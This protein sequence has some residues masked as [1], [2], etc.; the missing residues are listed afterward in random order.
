MD[1]SKRMKNA[2]VLLCLCGLQAGQLVAQEATAWHPAGDKIMSPWAEELTTASPLPEYPR[3]QLV[4][5]G[6]QNLN[7]LWDYAIVPGKLTEVPTAYSG[8]ILVPFAVESALSGV[9]K[10]V[11]KD[12]SLWYRR[13]VAI[14][15]KMRNQRVLLHFGAVDWQCEVYVNGQQAGSHEGGFDPFTIDITPYL[16]KGANQEI[17]VGVWDPTDE[18]PQP[19]GKQVVRPHG[20]WY[21]PVTG[22]WQTVW[23]EGVPETYI[24][25]TKH[26]PDIDRSSLAVEATIEGLRQGDEVRISAWNGSEKVAEAA[27][28]GKSAITLQLNNPQLWSPTNP[29]LYDLKVAVIRKGKAVDEV[30]SYFAMRKISMEKDK[31]GIQ[32]MLLN[33]E[34]VFQYGPLDQG[35]WPDGLYTAPTDEALRFD[36]EKTKDMGFNMIRKHI[37]VEPARWYYYCDSIGVLVWQDMPSGD[38]G[39]NHWDMRPGITSGKQHDKDRSA[40]SEAIYRKEWKAIIDALYNFPSIVVWVPFNEAWGQFKTKEI[41]Q[42]TV[43]YDQSRLVNSAS[44]GNFFPVG[45]ILDIHNYPDAVMPRPELFGE[46]QILVLG[47]FG[48]LGLPIEGHTWQNKD[49]WGYQSFKNVDELKNRYRGMVNDLARLIPLGLSAAVYTQT[50]DVEVETNGLMTYDRKV[51]KMP[52]TELKGWHQRLYDIRI[53]Q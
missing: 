27:G 17:V 13:T 48:G 51:V 1:K 45:H 43:D 12:S 34:F 5:E 19:N 21:T 52:E 38:L 39:G 23:L 31:K 7:G 10:T 16:A 14:D 50:T 30:S 41:T 36:V 44:G 22:I 2:L 40:E 11:G 18:G 26:T 6:W 25:S 49:N 4:R 9:G 20:I 24:R 53:D 42:W 35:W 29:F 32:R 3:P 15:K 47:E 8:E 46:K 28:D 37:K 33:N